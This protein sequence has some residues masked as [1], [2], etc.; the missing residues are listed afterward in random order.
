M[1]PLPF[2]DFFVWVGTLPGSLYLREDAPS[3]FGTSLTIHVLSL[4]LFLG[5][6]LMM[7]LR[8]LGLAHRE[9]P[10][11]QI[12]KRLFPWQLTGAIIMS[13]SGLVLFY[14][15]PVLYWGKGF[16][17]VKMLVALPLAMANL[18]VFH[19]TT[20]RSVVDWDNSPNPPLAA[21]VA[22]LL[23][24]VLWI[25]VL[26]FGRLVAYDWWTIVEGIPG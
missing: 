4:C 16:Y 3:F 21:K 11:S 22:G 7:D 15:Q 17:W 8:L 6:V 2:R 14:A 23:S 25:T 12:Q 24:I 18:L 9:T 10:V 20:Y 13:I 5:L 26:C 1:W 19:F